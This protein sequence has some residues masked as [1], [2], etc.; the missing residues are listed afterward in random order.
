MHALFVDP[1]FNDDVT[2]S[3]TEKA[4]TEAGGIVVTD[5]GAL[6]HDAMTRTIKTVGQVRQL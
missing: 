2:K 1:H 6:V 5:N 3:M 4:A